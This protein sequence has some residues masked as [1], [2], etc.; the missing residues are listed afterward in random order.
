MSQVES[1]GPGRSARKQDSGTRMAYIGSVQFNEQLEGTGGELDQEEA[2]QTGQREKSTDIKGETSDSIKP[3]HFGQLEAGIPREK[4]N[5]NRL[6]N[7]WVSLIVEFARKEMTVRELVELKEQDVIDLD[8]L[9]GE[10]FELR[11]NGRLFA[12]GEVGVVGDA[13]A[14]RITG[15]VEA[16]PGPDAAGE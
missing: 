13:M 7:V 6:N 4:T 10:P 8:K 16:G 1:Q 14:V 5:L 12:F 11:V 3:V 15:L 2:E 9:P